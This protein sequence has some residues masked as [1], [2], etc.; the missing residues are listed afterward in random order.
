[1]R[2]WIPVLMLAVTF[3]SGAQ[4]AYGQGVDDIIATIQDAAA[5]HGVSGDRLVAVARCETGGT[6]N[7]RAVGDHGTSLGIFQLHSP[8]LRETFFARG[9]SDPFDVAEASEFAAWA[10]ANGLARHWTCAR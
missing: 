3:A 2:R 9:F 5:R 1:M 7:P 8:G 6:F 10:F 4:Q